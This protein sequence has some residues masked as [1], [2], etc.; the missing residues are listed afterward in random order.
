MSLLRFEQP[1]LLTASELVRLAPVTELHR[2]LIGCHRISGHLKVWGLCAS[3]SAAQ[4]IRG[5]ISSTFSRR[6]E[7]PADC[8]TISIEAPGA[9]TVV[10]GGR[11][12]ARLRDG[13]II[14]ANEHPFRRAEEP[15][16]RFFL[17]IVDC[18]L[19]ATST[20]APAETLKLGPNGLLE[21]CFLTIAGILERIRVERHG[22]SI[23]LA[24]SSLQ[25]ELAYRTYRVLEHTALSGQILAH[26][27]SWES[28]RTV[29]D[30]QM[31]DPSELDKF[32]AEAEIRLTSERLVRGVDR[33]SLLAAIDGAVLLDGSLRL[34]AFGVRFPLLLTPGTSIVDA[35]TGLSYPCDE[36]GL[37]H[38]S[39][40]SVCNH[41]DD[42]MGFVVSQDGSVKA[43]KSVDGCLTFWDGILD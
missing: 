20:P 25:G 42:S 18:I 31:T 6:D 29:A 37:R 3:T 22:G 8:L 11:E 24:L 17:K 39:I 41:S 2:T 21:V 36:W 35:R 16:G 15:L 33:L 32:R 27:Q 12:L 19:E 26:C 14:A 7:L 28:F 23:V 1:A 13:K 40:F 4:E 9:L 38:Q 10:R 34:E 30:L 5:R 43:V